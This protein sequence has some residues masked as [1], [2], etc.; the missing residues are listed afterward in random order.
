MLGYSERGIL[1]S[2]L[3]EIQ[4]AGNVNALLG[5]LIDQAVSPEAKE[6][7]PTGTATVLVE[8]SLSDFGDADA[9]ILIESEAGKCAVFVEAKVR[10][11]QKPHWDLSVEWCNFQEWVKGE[12][13][14]KKTD[15]PK[16]VNSSNIFAQLYHK[17]QFAQHS[18]NKLKKGI[19]F[20]SWSTK[21]T[22]RNLGKNLIVLNAAKLIK[23]YSDNSF[24]LMLIPDNDKCTDIF[25]KNTLK[26][27]DLSKEVPGWDTTRYGYL[28]WETVESFCCDNNLENTLAVFEYNGEQIYKKH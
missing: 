26:N 25:F 24:Y 27:A 16:K 18:I 13:L 2:L 11:Q 10:R 22:P 23:E 3:S 9:V 6:K 12:Q 17:Q 20:P 5:R 1:N 7:P 21:N 8:Q 4:Y 15:K 14:D 28:T 19:C